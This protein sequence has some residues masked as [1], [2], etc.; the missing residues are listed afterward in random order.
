MTMGQK[1][2]KATLQEE[3]A[4]WAAK[5]RYAEPD[6]GRT[7]ARFLAPETR[8]AGQS[9]VEIPESL[10]QPGEKAPVH[11]DAATGTIFWESESMAR[12]VRL[13]RWLL[14]P[15]KVAATARLTQET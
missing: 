1:C 14:L 11:F 4:R 3:R 12:F 8:R 13:L 5:R 9:L 7:S 6:A 15:P 2:T 10:G